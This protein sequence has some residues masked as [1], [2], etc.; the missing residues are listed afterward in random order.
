MGRV[1]SGNR[2]GQAG[3][4]PGGNR[5]L[6]THTRTPG[7]KEA[8]GGATVSPR[9]RFFP[10]TWLPDLPQ[11]RTHWGA[12]LPRVQAAGGPSAPDLTASNPAAQT[13]GVTLHSFLRRGKPG[14]GLA[15]I[16][17]AG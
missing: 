16:S 9:R 4:S 6:N 3:A 8:A 14:S 15:F 2:K 12:G 17:R 5:I 11:S 7:L 1:G 13:Q 10:E